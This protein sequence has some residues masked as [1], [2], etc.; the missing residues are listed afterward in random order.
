MPLIGWLIGA[1]LKEII[2]KFDHWIAFVLLA[3]LGI[4]MILESLKSIEEKTIDI[5]NNK[6]LFLLSLATS[7][8]ALV[9]GMTFALLPINIWLAVII[10]G[11][12][13]FFLSLISIYIGKKCGERW[14]KKAEI[15]GG[16]ILI[17]IGLK[18][19]LTH[20]FF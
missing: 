10:I 3:I 6:I 19:L 15:I 7:I 16:I 5:H 20:L 12:T 4:K 9:I 17:L 11:L 8:D 14:G 13:T 18:I 1:G 2:S